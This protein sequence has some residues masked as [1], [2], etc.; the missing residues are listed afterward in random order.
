[1]AIPFTFFGLCRR[2][3]QRLVYVRTGLQ[4][5]GL[6]VMQRQGNSVAIKSC[7]HK[8]CAVDSTPKRVLTIYATKLFPRWPLLKGRKQAFL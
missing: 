7:R 3:G 8:Q 1:M 2:F 6:K 4:G 5:E